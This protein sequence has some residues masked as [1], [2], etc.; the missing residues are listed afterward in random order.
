MFLREIYKNLG[1]GKEVF[2]TKQNTLGFVYS[3]WREVLFERCMRLFKWQC[4]E[5]PQKEIEQNLIING[6]AGGLRNNKGKIVVARCTPYQQNVYYDEWKYLTYSLPYESGKREIGKDA[7]LFSN[8][9]IRN[10]LLPLIHHYAL[11]LAHTDVSIQ[12][13]LVNLRTTTVAKA[14]SKPV[15]K[16]IETWQEKIYNGEQ[17]TILDDFLESVAI[18]KET[19]ANTNLINLMEL[20]RQL[21]SNFYE[22]IGIQSNYEKKERLVVEEAKM[23]KGVLLVNINDMFEMRQKACEEMNA[24]FGTNW[25][26]EKSIEYKEMNTEKEVEEDDN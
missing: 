24:L 15:A 25:S 13:E 21:I 18:E 1:D 5:V 20:R 26:V 17:Y 19:H 8:T 2:T 4:P 22:D 14:K 11:L 6:M 23:N 10:P 12:C 3:Y 9:Q 16:S 7:V